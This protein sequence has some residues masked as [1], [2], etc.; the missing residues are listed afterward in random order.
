[1]LSNLHIYWNRSLK[2]I[3]NDDTRRVGLHPNDADFATKH[4]FPFGFILF[5]IE[6]PQYLDHA[7]QLVVIKFRR[8]FED[9]AFGQ[10]SRLHVRVG[11]CLMIVRTLSSNSALPCPGCFASFRKKTKTCQSYSLALPVCTC[12]HLRPFCQADHARHRPWPRQTQMYAACVKRICHVRSHRL[13]CSDFF[14][15]DFRQQLFFAR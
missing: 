9:Y 13:T 2:T 1:V 6:V 3:A 10:F 5:S 8:T 12:V 4:N 15:H 11:I 7:V 14:G